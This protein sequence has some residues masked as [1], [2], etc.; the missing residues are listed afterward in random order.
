MTISS[1]SIVLVWGILLKFLILIP[2]LV[3][4]SHCI[5]SRFLSYQRLNLGVGGGGK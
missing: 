4:A 3:P 2:N 1:L 5:A